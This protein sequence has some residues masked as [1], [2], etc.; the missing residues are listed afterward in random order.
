VPPQDALED[1]VEDGQYRLRGV[2]H[3]RVLVLPVP[4]VQLVRIFQC[5]IS[6]Q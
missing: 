3:L 4:N 6:S 5:E 2:I 1:V